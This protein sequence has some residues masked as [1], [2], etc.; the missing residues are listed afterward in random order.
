MESIKG[1]I[2]VDD[3]DEILMIFQEWSYINFDLVKK[4]FNGVVDVV[5]LFS[6]LI[7]KQLM[8]SDVENG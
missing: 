4:L 7:K 8:M 3:I 1:K 6:E 2:E 5:E